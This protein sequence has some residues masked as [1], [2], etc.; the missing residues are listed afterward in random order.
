MGRKR[1]NAREKRAI[2][3]LHRS[4]EW[5]GKSLAKLFDIS[6]GRV[7]QLLRNYYW[8]H[9]KLGVASGESEE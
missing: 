2:I 3:N 5:K 9:E 8:E 6:P 4:G 7:S 1:L